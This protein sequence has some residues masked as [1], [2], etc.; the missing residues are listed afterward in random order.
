MP[1]AVS[2]AAASA[3]TNLAEIAPALANINFDF[4][5]YK[6]E[7]PVEYQGVGSA[8]SKLRKREAESGSS[9]VIARKLGALFERAT[10]S[11]PQLFRAY[12]LRASEI[13]ASPVVNRLQASDYGF[14][15]SRVGADATSLWA[16][17]TSGSASIAMHLLA[18][19]LARIWDAPQATAIWV[20]LVQQRTED[21]VAEFETQGI[22]DASSLMAAQQDLSRSQLADWDASARAWLQLADEVMKKQQTQARLIVDSLER[23]SVNA[24]PKLSDSVLH[25][26]KAA[27]EQMESLAKGEPQRSVSGEVLLALL[28]WHL[29]PNLVIMG[30]SYAH[31]VNVRQED[32]LLG[33]GNVLT[34]GLQRHGEGELGEGCGITWSLPLAHLRYYGKP[35]MSSTS[36]NRIERSR[37]NMEELLFTA[38]GCILQDWKGDSIAI[39]K[40]MSLLKSFR[41]IIDQA[42]ADGNK[43]AKALIELENGQS[44]LMLILDAATRFFKLQDCEKNTAK[45]L[46]H[47]GGSKGSRFL[48]RPES[49]LFGLLKVSSYIPAFC[50]ED[51]IST[52]REIAVETGIPPNSAIIRYKHE[53]PQR[54]FAIEYATALPI[55]SRR[56]KR[57]LQ[58][59]YKASLNHV[60][61][62]NKGD[63]L[64]ILPR[65]VSQDSRVPGYSHEAIEYENLSPTSHIAHVKATQATESMFSQ[66]LPAEDVT[67]KEFK[68]RQAMISSSGEQVYH[69]DSSE[70]LNGETLDPPWEVFSRD[71]GTNHYYRACGDDTAA[72]F[73]PEDFKGGPALPI[74][75]QEESVGQRI[76]PEIFQAGNAN[77][78]IIVDKLW[79]IL[80]SLK[81][82]DPDLVNSMRDLATVVRLY[83][84]M[85]NDTVDVRVL[86]RPISSGEWAQFERLEKFQVF[87]QKQSI[88]SALAPKC[89][90]R[91]SA[92]SCICM[93]ESGRFDIYPEDLGNAFALSCDNSLFIA[94]SLLQDPGEFAD[95]AEIRRVYGNVG[96]AGI[97]FLVLPQDPMIREQDLAV[98]SLLDNAAFDSRR[99]DCFPATTLHLSFTGLTFPIEVGT[100]GQRDAEVY[101]LESVVSVHDR[102]KWV[103]DLDVA[104]DYS[105]YLHHFPKKH[106][107]DHACGES[108]DVSSLTSIDS[109]EEVLEFPLSDC[110]FRAHG[111]WQARLAV[112]SILI[113]RCG[114]SGRLIKILPQK[115]ICW[116]CC[117]GLCTNT[118]KTWIID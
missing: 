100:F 115:G 99:I 90:D 48:G 30:E 8:L 15:A 51:R 98:W 39:I 42:A 50:E 65:S 81:W 31:S 104:V 10:P 21:I 52:L 70:T 87:A 27:L 112:A 38:L 91:S 44:W 69:L 14:F 26:W 40:M 101:K 5:L 76:L 11:T 85:D 33:R 49:P 62:L 53:F 83:S 9:H 28:S 57:D 89:L 32:P 79:R 118:V 77:P 61:W 13:I 84:K 117:M 66:S 54:G 111:N 19:M 24:N 108:R 47:L 86:R 88:P 16:A 68:Y 37:I 72:L 41:A 114:G 43:Q 12:G 97:A 63:D 17:A 67:S 29:Y 109:W 2:R 75:E 92:L 71:W 4:S 106:D 34:I 20:Q 59:E 73:F 96:R 105:H 56:A 36:M 103:A 60:R 93:F 23:T 80:D 64:S 1:L 107:H 25:T 6:V 82:A 45:K 116:N 110:V 113:Q 58:G 95:H 74:P 94:S 46:I 22:G 102:G 55:P 3:V 78:R 7:A 35:V 18:C